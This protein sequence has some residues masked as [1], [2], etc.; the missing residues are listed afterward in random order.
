VREVERVAEEVL[1]ARRLTAE[2]GVPVGWP[3]SR[4]GDDRE[5]VADRCMFALLLL[6]T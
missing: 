2:C 1:T 4:A 3:Q 6:T 5:C